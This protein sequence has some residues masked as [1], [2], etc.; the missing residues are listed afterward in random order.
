MWICPGTIAKLIIT[1]TVIASL[2]SSLVEDLK[3][4]NV[5]WLFVLFCF[6][7]LAHTGAIIVG[8]LMN[9][10][11]CSWSQWGFCRRVALVVVQEAS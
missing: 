11:F 5:D 2:L 7:L 9:G 8:A 4:E 6:G 3:S 10:W 1:V